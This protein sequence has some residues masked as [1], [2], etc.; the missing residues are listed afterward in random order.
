M[1][2]SQM[3]A[4]DDNDRSVNH[5]LFNNDDAN[6]PTFLAPPLSACKKEATESK[7]KHREKP[8]KKRGK[9]L[10][11]WVPTATKRTWH[12]PTPLFGVGLC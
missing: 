9:P 4:A 3:G 12:T 2:S 8:N 10:R 11:P 6:F 5:H 7:I 1:D